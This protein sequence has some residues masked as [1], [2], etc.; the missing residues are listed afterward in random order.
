M[1][2]KGLLILLLIYLAA[3]RMKNESVAYSMRCHNIRHIDIGNVH[4]V[5]ASSFGSVALRQFLT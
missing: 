4:V 5:V 3:R 1:G 2:R